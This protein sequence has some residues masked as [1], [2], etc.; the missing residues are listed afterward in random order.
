MKTGDIL[1][2]RVLLFLAILILS[3]ISLSYGQESAPVMPSS[4]RP[5]A[6]PSVLP[7]SPAKS[8]ISGQ[9]I[10]P[11]IPQEIRAGELEKT[12]EKPSLEEQFPFPL[13]ISATPGDTFVDVSWSPLT[14]VKI[15][16]FQI[17]EPVS[18]YFIFYGTES[19]NYTQKVDVG[20]VSSYRIRNL[21]N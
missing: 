17:E 11:R 3:T 9:G 16:E 7:T 4:N 18:G 15:E 2:I 19:G 6:L 13:D 10:L 12:L 20:E 14:S 1:K 21:K 5:S 8:E